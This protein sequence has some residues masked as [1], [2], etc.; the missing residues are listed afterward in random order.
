MT[1]WSRIAAAS[2]KLPP[3]QTTAV[4]VERGLTAKMPDGAELLA[5]RWY[6]TQPTGDPATVLI[7]TPYGRTLMGPLGRLYAERGYQVIVQSCRGTFGSGGR[8]RARAQRAGRRASH[9]RVGGGTTLVRRSPRHVGRQLSRHDAVGSGAGRAGLP[10]GDQLRR[11]LQRTSATRS[12]SPGGAFALE[13]AL[14][15]LHEIK[16]QELG[17]QAVAADAPAGRPDRVDIERC[18]AHRRVRRRRHRRADGASI[19]SG[20]RTAPR[21]TRGGTPSTSG[22]RSSRCRRPASSGAGTTSSSGRR[23]TTTRRFVAPGARPD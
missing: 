14:A 6:P 22:A 7:R 17:W 10:A 4:S 16:N 11:S 23:S 13:T 21:V 8:V 20:S 12:C 18:P 9:A 2:V 19:R 15:W 3:P 5:D 1:V